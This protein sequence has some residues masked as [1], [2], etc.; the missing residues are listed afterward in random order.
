M[1]LDYAEVSSRDIFESGQLYVGLFRVTA[2]E[3]LTLN[4]FS[5]KQL[6]MDADVLRF[7]RTTPW[8]NLESSDQDK[9]AN[10]PKA[11]TNLS[12][13]LSGSD[14]QLHQ[15]LLPPQPRLVNTVSDSE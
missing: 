13:R 3:G 6:R 14:E 10:S 5:R 11:I 1:T 15:K 4:E 7:Y 12:T 8:I 2:L 9:N